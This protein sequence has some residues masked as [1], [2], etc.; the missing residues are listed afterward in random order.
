M[1]VLDASVALK[2]FF[3]D[4]IHPNAERILDEILVN[5][6]QFAVPELFSFEVLA[7]LIRL[8]PEPLAVY[9]QGILPILSNGLLRYPMTESLAEKA[10]SLSKKRGLTGYDATYAALAEEIQGIWL[11]Y[12]QKAHQLLKDTGL[13]LNL[14][15]D[16]I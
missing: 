5:P 2:W 4:E 12:D 6:G 13:S 3:I 14:W 9:R 8:H 11:T 15:E 7:V 1:Y 16:S 10:I